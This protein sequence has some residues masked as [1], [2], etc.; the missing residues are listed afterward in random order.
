MFIVVF[1]W[2]NLVS[3]LRLPHLRVFVYALEPQVLIMGVWQKVRAVL[4]IIFGIVMAF[5]ACMYVVWRIIKKYVPNFPIPLKMIFLKIPPLPQ[6]ERAGLFAFI[7][8]VLNALGHFYNP[9]AALTG[10]LHTFRNFMRLNTWRVLQTIGVANNIQQLTSAST[11]NVNTYK[12]EYDRVE[13][14]KRAAQERGKIAGESPFTASQ[15]LRVDEEYV[16]CVEENTIPVSEDMSKSER[17]EI[18]DK[19]TSARVSCQMNG[20]KAIFRTLE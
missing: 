4:L 13:A 10:L 7:E 6:L 20:I 11:Y 5:I 17:K 12:G 15:Y 19:N 16:Q 1:I 14:E 8:G 2:F 3:F 9:P 18:I